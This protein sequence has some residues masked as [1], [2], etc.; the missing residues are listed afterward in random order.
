MITTEAVASAASGAIR[1]P[2]W[3]R[4]RPTARQQVERLMLQRAQDALGAGDTELFDS[5]AGKLLGDQPNTREDRLDIY[6]LL[7]TIIMVGAL[8]A[9]VVV[10][11]GENKPA[12]SLF[13]FVSLASGLAGIGLGWLF[14]TGTAR[15]R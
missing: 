3:F 2:G 1:R 9:I 5:L 11:V 10:I 14:G 6:R 13:Q 8:F 7:A 15:R 12:A 4:R